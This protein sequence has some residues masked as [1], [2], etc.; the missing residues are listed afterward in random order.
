MQQ[1]L[2]STK[3]SKLI[4]SVYPSSFSKI[5]IKIKCLKKKTVFTDLE[6]IDLDHCHS[7]PSWLALEP[8]S[9]GRLPGTVKVRRL[10]TQ[11]LL[12]SFS[13]YKTK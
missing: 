3:L 6:N 4:P 1:L 8:D 11:N 5:Q 7:T 10:S 2:G 13:I 12:K 9:H